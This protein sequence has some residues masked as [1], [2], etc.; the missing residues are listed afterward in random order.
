MYCVDCASAIATVATIAPNASECDYNSELRTNGRRKWRCRLLYP[1]LCM[2]NKMSL[3]GF[4][5]ERYEKILYKCCCIP[6]V[7]HLF[8]AMISSPLPLPPI[9]PPPH[10]LPFR[11]DLLIF[12]PLFYFEYFMGI[13]IRHVCMCVCSYISRTLFYVSVIVVFCCC[14]NCKDTDADC[15]HICV[16]ILWM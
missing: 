13:S 5:A 1:C 12:L 14:C 2:H 15:I 6:Y 4:Y 10:S 9:H 11:K 8:T 3:K 7:V 16:H